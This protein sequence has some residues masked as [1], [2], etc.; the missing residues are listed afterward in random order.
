LCLHASLLC[1]THPQSG[2]RLRFE[3]P[4]PF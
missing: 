2:E 1:L 3:S 4:A